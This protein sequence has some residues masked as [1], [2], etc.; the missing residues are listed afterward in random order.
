MSTEGERALKV[1]LLRRRLQTEA[2]AL[3]VKHEPSLL[4]NVVELF[5]EWKGREDILLQELKLK[6]S[7]QVETG[8]RA[9]TIADAP[10]ARQAKATVAEA[11]DAALQKLIEID[12]PLR[13]AATRILFSRSSS[14]CSKPDYLK[15][16]HLINFLNAS[17]TR[18]H[19]Y[20]TAEGHDRF[21]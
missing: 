11:T 17:S 5:E 8:Y 9:L 18:L 20:F 2:L 7:G 6:Y 1:V 14:H 13:L 19:S 10:D 3:M 4:T 15:A 16:V 21:T 12:A